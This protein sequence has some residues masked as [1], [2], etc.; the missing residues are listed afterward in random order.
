MIVMI[1]NPE[2]WQS[3]QKRGIKKIYAVSLLCKVLYMLLCKSAL[4]WASA[5]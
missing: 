4:A 5:M 1:V 2:S 3:L